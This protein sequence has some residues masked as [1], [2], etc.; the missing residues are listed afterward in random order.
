MAE[1]VLPASAFH[2]TP[3]V[4]AI[5]LVFVSKPLDQDRAR[6]EAIVAIRDALHGLDGATLTGLGVVGHDAEATVRRD[7]PRLALAAIGLAAVYL[8]IHFRNLANALLSLVPAVFGMIVAAAVLRL[9]GEKLNM[10]NLIAI[11]LLIGIDVDYGIFLV[12]LTRPRK[13]P[14][15]MGGRGS[16]STELTE[17]RRAEAAPTIP[18]RRTSVRPSSN[19]S[20][21]LP[22][23]GCTRAGD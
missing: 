10:I 6:D 15:R 18:A 20:L 13:D 4:E 14:L 1:T 2:G 16:G 23:T 9:A 5:T 8:I 17:V 19:R 12:S 7:L 22:H 11:P 21:A 3:P